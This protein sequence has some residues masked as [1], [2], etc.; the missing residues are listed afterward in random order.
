MGLDMYLEAR[1]YVSQYDYKG[2][3]RI[4]TPEFSALQ[5]ASGISD[6]CKFSDFGGMTVSYPVGYWRKAN[7][8][9]GWFVREC[10]GGV[11]ECQDI[12]VPREKLVELRDACKAI[13]SVHAGSVEQVVEENGL[14]PTSGF[15]FGSYEIDEWYMQDMK[16]TV[17][18][19]DHVLSIIPEDTWEWSFNYRASW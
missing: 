13:A 4:R 1:K 8:I 9:H 2:A 6:L 19:L 10:G 7:A 12:Y 17:E 15:F 16:Q 14:M 18:M 11:D 3:D 5:D